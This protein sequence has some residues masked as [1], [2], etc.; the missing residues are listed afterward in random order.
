VAKSGYV[1]DGSSWIPFTAP[2]GAVPNAVA[3]YG[4]IAPTNPQI[5]QIWTDVSTDTLKIWSG[6]SWNIIQSKIPINKFSDSII[7]DTIISY[8]A[9]SV[10]P[11]RVGDGVI[12]TV[13]QG[14]VWSII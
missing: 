5:G 9:M 12:V 1:W 7:S 3:D 6:S 2:V 11:V 14:S 10:G 4:S 8:N 13:V